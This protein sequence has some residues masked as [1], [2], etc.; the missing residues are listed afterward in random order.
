MT[1]RNWQNK[2][3]TREKIFAS[4]LFKPF[5]PWFEHD[6]FWAFDRNR[7][8]LAAAIGLYCGMIPTPFQFACA[9][10]AAYLLRA[11]LP[12][13]LFATLYTNPITLVPLYI[14]AYKL[15]FWLLYGDL[16]RSELVMPH[17]DDGHF[18][19]NIGRWA[20]TFGKPWLLGSIL[21]ASVFAVGGYMAVQLLWR[22]GAD[23]GKH[24]SEP[25]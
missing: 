16:P 24:T 8:A 5:A 25:S 2:L 22:R 6:Y 20:A 21:M 23:N 19:Q 9:F 3:P 18:W 7:V 4:R 1:L 12:V 13:A 14:A 15:G 17:F 11:N 10:A